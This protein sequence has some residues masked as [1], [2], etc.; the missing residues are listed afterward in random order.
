MSWPGGR[1]ST[2]ALAVKSLC[3]SASTNTPR[4]TSRKLSVVAI[5][6]CMRAGRSVR[7]Q[8]TPLSR[9][10]SPD[11]TPWVISGRSLA[12]LMYGRATL[13]AAAEVD[14]VRNFRRV[15]R[16]DARMSAFL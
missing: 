5:S 13:S 6:I 15:R 11:C 10:T 7:A 4:R 12:R 3:G 1:S 8:I 14:T 9:P 2:S 16:A